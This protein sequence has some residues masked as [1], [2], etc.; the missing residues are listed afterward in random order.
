MGWFDKAK[1]WGAETPTWSKDL[2]FGINEWTNQDLVGR[3]AA[4][5]GSIAAAI[6]LANMLAGNGQ[7]QQDYGSYAASQAAQHSY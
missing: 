2:P 5:A 7:Q 1:A 6:A 3:P 4:A